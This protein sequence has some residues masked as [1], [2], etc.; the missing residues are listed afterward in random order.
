MGKRGHQEAWGTANCNRAGK[1]GGPNVRKLKKKKKEKNWEHPGQNLQGESG[2]QPQRKGGYPVGKGR[3][4]E[5]RI[6]KI[7]EMGSLEEGFRL[8]LNQRGKGVRKPNKNG[9]L[10][11]VD[12]EKSRHRRR[13]ILGFQESVPGGRTTGGVERKHQARKRSWERRAI[14]LHIK[15]PCTIKGEASHEKK[16]GRI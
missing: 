10:K 15:G 3:G 2:I 1:K 9:R 13:R 12:R 8:G 5:N 4:K 11:E 14:A 7:I 16:G 6:R